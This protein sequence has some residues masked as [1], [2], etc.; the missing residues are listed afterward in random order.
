[1]ELLKELKQLRSEAD[2]LSVEPGIAIKGRFSSF[3]GTWYL[4]LYKRYL[5]GPSSV[6]GSIKKLDAR[7]EKLSAE[8]EALSNEEHTSTGNAVI[9]FNWV[10]DAANMLH[11]YNLRNTLANLFVPPSVGRSFNILTGGKF[12]RTERMA[13]RSAAGNG[14]DTTT[15][16]PVTVTRAP[17]P[18]DLLWNNTQFGGWPIVKRRIV[19]W[20]CNLSFSL[21]GKRDCTQT[22]SPV[23][24]LSFSTAV[25]EGHPS[26][27]CI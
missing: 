20:V 19:A 1:M 16:Q 2:V 22:G 8:V 12:A 7:Y 14:E 17:E 26:C 6:D 10:P 27:C 3:P 18:S 24:S 13:I 9:V 11:N 21:F 4:W 23:Y 15:Y 5:C 25:I